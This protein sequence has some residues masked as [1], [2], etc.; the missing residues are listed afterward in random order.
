MV[1]SILLSVCANYIYDYLKLALPITKDNLIA[2]FANKDCTLSEQNVQRIIDVIQDEQLANQAN[3][4]TQETFIQNLENNNTLQQIVNDIN[5]SIDNRVQINADNSTVIIGTNHNFSD[6]S[7]Q[8]NTDGG[9]YNE[10]NHY[11]QV[12]NEKKL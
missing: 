10:T 5:N 12:S 8:I 6:N 11:T 7:R 3:Q 9:A 2:Y 4:L 1:E